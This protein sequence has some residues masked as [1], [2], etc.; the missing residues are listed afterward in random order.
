M[1]DE[2]SGSCEIEN[3]CKHANNLIANGILSSPIY[4]SN[5]ETNIS[6]VK[7]EK[8]TKYGIYLM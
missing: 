6:S 1:S 3:I 7:Y 8:D 2:K 5:H 4:N